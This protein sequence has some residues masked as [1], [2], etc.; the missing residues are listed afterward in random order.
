MKKQLVTEEQELQDSVRIHR[1]TVTIY[2]ELNTPVAA[3]IKPLQHADGSD[4]ILALEEYTDFLINVL[5][6]FDAHDF[7]VIEERESPYS[8]SYYC[9]LVKKDQYD[10]KNYKYILYVRLS[11]H[12]NKLESKHSTRQYYHQKAQDQKQ[13][14]TKSKQ[15]WRL[16]EITVNK[17]T[18]NS[19]DDA[20]DYIDGKLP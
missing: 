7:V 20:L 14:V 13:L 6:L 4:D 3:S 17:D 12:A 8:H 1:L 11:D 19:Y 2:L 9:A 5:E 10:A 18:F 15:T 16:K